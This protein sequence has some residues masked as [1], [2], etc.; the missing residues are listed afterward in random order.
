MLGSSGKQLGFDTLLKQH[1]KWQVKHRQVT[2]SLIILPVIFE[3][4]IIIIFSIPL[5]IHQIIPDN[6][7]GLK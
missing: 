3:D 6:L 1:T 7:C 2:P 5:I 4:V